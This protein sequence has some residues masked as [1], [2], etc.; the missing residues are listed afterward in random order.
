MWRTAIRAALWLCIPAGLMAGQV[1]TVVVDT[2]SVNSST[3]YVDL[4]FSADPTAQSA[5]VTIAEFT[6]ADLLGVAQLS[7]PNVAGTLP[8]TVTI[9]NTIGS[10][11]FQ[12]SS[13]YFQQIAFGPQL[14]F[15][16]TFAGPA[17]V[18]PNPSFTGGSTFA[19]ALYDS[20]LSALPTVDLA[21]NLATISWYSDGTTVVSAF[22]SDAAG[23]P[24]LSSVTEVAEPSLFPLFLVGAM[25]VLL[26][27]WHR[28]RA[29]L[30]SW[31]H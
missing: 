18:A 1:Y 20:D 13:D 26:G 7:G 2:S 10:G 23:G 11:T 6:P 27:K 8:G 25:G 28:R 30:T 17:A 12:Q 29:T 24:P 15:L 3:G 4:I 16:L 19:L 31:R 21:G 14:T 9:D 5:F 22:A